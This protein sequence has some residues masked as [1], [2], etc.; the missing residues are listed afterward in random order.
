MKIRVR[1]HLVSRIDIRKSSENLCS[2]VRTLQEA[3]I[4]NPEYIGSQLLGLC[5]INFLKNPGSH[6]FAHSAMQSIAPTFLATANG[7]LI[8]NDRAV[9]YYRHCVRP[10]KTCA[11]SAMLY[12]AMWD[13]SQRIARHFTGSSR[14]LAHEDMSLYKNQTKRE[15]RDQTTHSRI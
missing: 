15:R 13:W 9:A 3:G 1:N 11:C 4:Q 6:P 10:A 12:K 7:L 14:R 5:A 8:R 2:K